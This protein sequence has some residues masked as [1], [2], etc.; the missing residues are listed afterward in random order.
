M[1][2]RLANAQ[3]SAQPDRPP[4]N[5]TQEIAR[6]TPE[7]PALIAGPTEIR[8]GGYLGVTGIYRSTGS[9][10]GTGT[11]FATIPYDDT[12]QGN[13][14]EA[15]LS[16][17]ASRLSIRVNAAPAEHRSMLA[18]Y[19]EMDFNGATP[20]NVAVTSTSVGFR[21][22]NAFGEAQFDHR[23]LVAAGQMYT[24]MTPAKD[25]LSAWPSDYELTYAVDMN[26]VAGMVW[27]RVPQVR[28]TYRPTTAFNWAVSVE[29]PEQQL[30]EA[31]V[32]LPQC[33]VADLETQFN[34]G[35]NN[36]S[37]PN[38]MP[39]MTS[40]VAVNAGKRLHVDAGGVFRLF[41][42][43]VEPYTT[44]T[45][46]AGGGGSVNARVTL[47][48]P[49]NVIG[50]FS[51]GA[52][53][54]R[55]IGGLM[56]DVTVSADGRIHPVH[57]NSWVAGVEYRLSA[58][59]SIAAYDSGV[60]ARAIYSTDADGTYI[61]FGYPGAPNADNEAIHEATG[62]FAWRAWE[63]EGRGSMQWTTQFSWLTRTP[64]SAG[65]NHSSADAVLFLT[66]LR[67]NLP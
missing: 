33:C 32:K 37:V 55:Y 26:Y 36:L 28:F 41:R 3:T 17:Q 27:G 35:D 22:R 54:G 56:P 62:V 1:L 40:R 63:I 11:S 5:P 7:G 44:S 60:R 39:D 12:A 43:T 14:S 23:F 53:M 9:G 2:A 25:Q 65:T 64:F 57:T 6:E 21:L 46:Q 10:G 8:I 16:A 4:S 30:G 52:G 47:A 61:G 49:V 15:R 24:L 38:L 29:N 58:R 67:Y 13:L 19:F 48:G 18:G 51:Y 42:D 31:V 50:Q 20:G 66:Q 45:K 34:T 59:A